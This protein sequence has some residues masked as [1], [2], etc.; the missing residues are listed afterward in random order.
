VA[1]V[2]TKGQRVRIPSETRLT[3]TLQDPVRW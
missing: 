1:E 2:V 3:F